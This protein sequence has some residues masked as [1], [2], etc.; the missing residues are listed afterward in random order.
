MACVML[1]VEVVWCQ[2]SCL[3]S[4]KEKLFG[5]CHDGPAVPSSLTSITK[6]CRSTT[7]T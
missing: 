2:K 3:V 1:A 4:E 7:T 5:I 6:K